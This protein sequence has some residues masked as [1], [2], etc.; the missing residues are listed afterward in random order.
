[1]SPQEA[2]KD[3]CFKVELTELSPGAKMGRIQKTI[4]TIV[5]DDGLYLL[6]ANSKLNQK[7]IK[8]PHPHTLTK[9]QSVRAEPNDI[10]SAVAQGHRSCTFGRIA[11]VVLLQ[12]STGW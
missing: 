12:S 2:E 8:E 9:L 4:V 11:F 5:N 7:S 10:F 3:E 6:A 1:M